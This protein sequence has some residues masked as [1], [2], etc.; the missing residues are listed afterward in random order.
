MYKGIGWHNFELINNM[1]N[2]HGIYLLILI[3]LAAT[4]YKNRYYL[5]VKLD[6]QKY[7][8][9]Y[10]TSQYVLGDASN[11]W[12]SDS[13]L[14]VYAGYAYWLGEDP[15]TI[16]FEHPPVAKYLYGAFFHILGNPY[17]GSVFIYLLVLILINLITKELLFSSTYRALTI[18]LTGTLS[19]LQ[20]H[21]IFSYIRFGRSC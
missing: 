9:K 3:L 17:W 1:I 12:I 20:V 7:E 18:V 14:Y 21:N 8:D 10:A 15:T 19:L 4:V 6:P 16:N 5:F 11:Y 13:D 2:K